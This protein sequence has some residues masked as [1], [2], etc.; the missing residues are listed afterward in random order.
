[1]NNQID[2]FT[3]LTED[4]KRLSYELKQIIVNEINQNGGVISFSKYMELALY[5]PQLGYYSN[6]LFKF[7]SQGDFITAPLV[8]NLFGF[9]LAKQFQEIFSFGVSNSVLE[10]GAGNGKLASDILQSIGEEIDK[11]YILELSAN[12]KSWQKQTLEKTVPQYLDK[13]VWLDQLPLHF[14]GVVIANEV[15]DAQ[16]FD[17]IRYDDGNVLGVGVGFY[18]DDFTYADTKLVNTTNE[19]VKELQ[20]DYHDYITEVHTANKQFMQTIAQMIGKGALIFI[21]YGSGEQEYYH[22]QKA[23]GNHRGF[24]RHHV[25]DS[26]LVYPGLIDITTNVNFSL[27]ATTAIENGLELIGYTTQGNFLLNC[28]LVDLMKQLHE[29][30]SNE[31]YLKVSNQVNKLISN[32]E[33]GELFKVI[34]FSK[35]VLESEWCGF[36][37]S[38]RSYLL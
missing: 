22:S 11:Y 25:L 33:M 36:T 30:L 27:V 26:V 12:L 31:Q 14:D 23:R 37:T 3:C 5:Y 9:L 10:F 18:G 34:G 1:M 35:G 4:E 28:G 32:N 19:I 15:L 7:G 13:V 2:I 8:S 21:D 29:K 17:L 16:P 24:F 38:D 20:Y 6:D